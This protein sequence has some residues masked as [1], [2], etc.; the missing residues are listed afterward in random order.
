[1]WNRIFQDEHYGSVTMT[2]RYSNGT[3]KAILDTISEE[4]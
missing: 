3:D 2:V 1:M 4:M